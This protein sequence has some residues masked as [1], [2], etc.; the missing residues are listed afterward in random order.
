MYGLYAPKW[1]DVL[2]QQYIFVNV[3]RS[4]GTLTVGAK[5]RGRA[6]WE[7]MSHTWFAFTTWNDILGPGM[8][9][10]S[11]DDL[12]LYNSGHNTFIYQARLLIRSAYERGR[13]TPLTLLPTRRFVGGGVPPPPP[14]FTAIAQNCPIDLREH[15]RQVV[16][17]AQRTGVWNLNRPRT[18]YCNLAGRC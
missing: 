14:E 16:E 6:E 11:L 4:N 12:I 10:V 13:N 18:P 5:L 7:P 15:L 9:W 3:P 2:P 8:K 1:K 17:E